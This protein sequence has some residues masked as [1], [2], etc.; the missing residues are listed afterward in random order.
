MKV[1]VVGSG[2]REHALVWKISQSPRVEKIYCA[3]GN[4]GISQIA[5]CVDIEAT[6]IK[7]LVQ[8][9]KKKRIDL[10]VIG[11]ELPLT[12][13][14]VDRFQE[15]GLPIFGPNR[16][17]AEIEG[18]KGFAKRFMKKYKIPTADYQIFTDPEEAVAYINKKE[19]PL[20]LKA[21]GLAA[22]KGVL[23][24]HTRS[25]LYDGID[26]I[27]KK[28][29]F[30]EAGSRLVIEEFLQGEEASVLAVTDGVDMVVFPPAQ[31]HKPIFEHDRGPN[32]GGMGAYAPAPVVDSKMLKIIRHKILDP[33]IKGMREE[34]REYRG[35]IYAGLMITTEGPKV[36]EFNCRFGDPETQ[37]I[38][39]LI[40]TDLVDLMEASIK[41]GV[42]EVELKI[43]KGF[44]VCVVI[45]SGGYPG[46]YEKG[47]T[48]HGLD[49][50]S[51]DTL[52]FHA[53]TKR[54]GDQLI[55]SGG[56][57]LGITCIDSS[58]K[59]AIEKTYIGVSRITFDGAYYRKD[60]GYRVVGK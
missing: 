32:T 55:T 21:D 51:S 53:C 37:A 3:P 50:V 52:V 49:D 22:G 33:T 38:L 57:V 42:G 23:V 36:L 20:V 7:G 18:S 31:D 2:G 45:A 15:N 48:I 26:Q 39:P 41:R 30:G 6:D 1:L 59:G 13:G 10:T 60:I 46:K 27:M 40:E 19:P 9:A 24:C 47:K 56:R 11:P 12:F 29:V 54:R 58:V 8:F 4:G 17:A 16:A 34:G 35:V 14:I 28:R 43:K 5:E 44:A 25:E